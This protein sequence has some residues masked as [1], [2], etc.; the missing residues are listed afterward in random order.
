MEDK[1]EIAPRRRPVYRI[2]RRGGPRP[3]FRRRG[4][5][6]PQI[7]KFPQ[8]HKG[9]PLCENR[10]LR[11]RG[12]H[13]PPAKGVARIWFRGGPHPFRGGPDPLFFASDPKSQGSP[14][15]YFW[16]PPD[17]GGGPGPPRPPLATPLPPA[18]PLYTGLP[19]RYT[20]SHGRRTKT[21]IFVFTSEYAAAALR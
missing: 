20:H 14:L 15:M 3:S 11:F 6:G 2:Q 18:P 21:Q 5:Q 4:G 19:R 7:S 10:D 16:L 9:P 8:N 17:F 13:G 12:G 1:V